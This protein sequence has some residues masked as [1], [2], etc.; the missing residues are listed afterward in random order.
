MGQ[1]SKSELEWLIG[2]RADLQRL[3]VDILFFL[4]ENP[5]LEAF[6][7]EHRST[8][9][10]FVGAGF[11]LWRAAFLVDAD[12]SGDSITSD[13]QDLLAKLIAENTISFQDDRR[14]RNWTVGYYLNNARHRIARIIQTKLALETSELDDV[15]EFTE[16]H[17]GSFDLQTDSRRA[18]QVCFDA[19]RHAFWVFRSRTE[20]A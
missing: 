7:N 17:S 6:G 13:A 10:L 12:R 14:M 15:R 5:K 19:L 9:S 3:L 16:F 18:W 11:S 8:V 1:Q 2:S 20:S 4:K